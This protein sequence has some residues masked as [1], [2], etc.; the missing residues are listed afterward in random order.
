MTDIGA[1]AILD[2]ATDRIAAARITDQRDPRRTGAALQFLDRVGKF[3]ALVLDR[4]AI[5]LL[6]LFVGA[7]KR[8]GEIDREHPIARHAVRFHSLHI[9]VIQSAAWSPLPYGPASTGN[10]PALL[11]INRRDTLFWNLPLLFSTLAVP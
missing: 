2:I 8:I 3:T 6:H 11:R 5:G 9:V 1:A 7:R 4:G 10:A